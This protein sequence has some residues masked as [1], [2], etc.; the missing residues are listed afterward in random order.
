MAPSPPLQLTKLVLPGMKE[1]R[2]GVVINIGSGI[3]T[4]CPSGPL[5]TVYAAT[6]VRPVWDSIPPGL[7]SG[8]AN[9]GDRGVR[10][11]APCEED[12]GGED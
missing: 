5:L 2:R 12:L 11:S 4:A 7:H 10:G 1:R 3:A 9:S 6:K 8:A